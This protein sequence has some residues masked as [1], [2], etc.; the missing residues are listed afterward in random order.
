M[1]YWDAVLGHQFEESEDGR[2]LFRP[3]GWRW[4]YVVPSRQEHERLRRQLRWYH[5]T[6]LVA[7][8][9]STLLGWVGLAVALVVSMLVYML[10]ALR[11]TRRLERIEAPI[12]LV[13]SYVAQARRSSTRQLWLLELAA[14]AFVLASI[15]IVFDQNPWVAIAAILFFGFGAVVFAGMLVVRR[16]DRAGIG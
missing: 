6:F 7:V 3:W 14:L 8:P 15:L 12:T 16:R 1:G 5:G 2:H 11:L 10:W 9:L 13:E 4:A